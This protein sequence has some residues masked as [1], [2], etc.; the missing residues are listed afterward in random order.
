LN[1]AEYR[2]DELA[3]ALDPK[4]PRHFMPVV[5]SG[6]TRILDVGC[7][8]GHIIEGLQLPA[9]YK[10][11][12]CDVDLEALELAKKFVPQ[13]SF[14]EASAEKLPYDDAAFDFVY[15]RGVAVLMDIPRAL[16]ELNRV[17]APGGSL[18][19][20]LHRVNDCWFIWKGT[21]KAHPFKTA[22]F[23]LYGMINGAFFH[24][25]GK[26]FRYPLNR[27]RMMSF[28]TES[29]IRKELEKAGFGNIRFDQG[30]FLVVTGVKVANPA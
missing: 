6:A 4:H 8:A 23:A 5:P 13:A 7:H 26:M 22:A 17:L 19:V 15:S 16:R 21:L 30:R 14:A 9:S 1:V 18:W 25:T 28:Q 27:S 3:V 11:C 10:V 29:R 24:V 2:K 12:G 20:S